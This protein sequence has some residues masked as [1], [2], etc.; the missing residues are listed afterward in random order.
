MPRN[1]LIRGVDGRDAL[2]QEAELM[3]EKDLHDVLNTHPGLLPADDL[4]VGRTIVVG[5]ESGLESGYA[6][7]VR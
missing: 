7:L 6:D 1:L 5:R 2:V 4:E 3:A